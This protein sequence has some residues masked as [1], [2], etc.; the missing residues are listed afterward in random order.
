MCYWFLG[1]S[2]CKRLR[3]VISKCCLNSSKH[4]KRKWFSK[5]LENNTNKKN[6]QCVHTF[7][8]VCSPGNRQQ[9]AAFEAIIWVDEDIFYSENL[10]AV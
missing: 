10:G 4:G 8:L 2:G 1:N 7:A 3:V 9:S 6:A 5:C